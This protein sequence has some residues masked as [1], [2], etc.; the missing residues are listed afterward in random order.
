MANVFATKDDTTV[1][2][3]NN[4]GDREEKA[5]VKAD[6][7]YLWVTAGMDPTDRVH[8]ELTLS[9]G[10][11]TEDRDIRNDDAFGDTSTLK[12]ELRVWFNGVR[13]DWTWLAS[14]RQLFRLG[15]EGRHLDATYDYDLDG[16]DFN[17]FSP[18][19]LLTFD[20]HIHESVEGDEYSAW[21][22]WR[23]QPVEPLTVELGLRWDKQTYTDLD[24]DDQVSPRIN[25]AWQ[26]EDD[27]RLR[28]AWGYFHQAQRINEMN[29]EDGED[30]FHPAQ[31][32]E[33]R[34]IGI[35]HVFD[36]GLSMRL[37]LYQKKYT[38]VIPRYE[39]LFDPLEVPGEA[40][41]DRVRIA[42]DRTEAHGVEFSLK[43][44]W[45]ERIDWWGSYT[46]S[47][48]EDHIDGQDIPR[49]WDQRHATTVG[50]N[51]SGRKWDFSFVHTFHSGWPRTDASAEIIADDD[52]NDI[53]VIVPGPRNNDNLDNYHRLDMRASRRVT[54]PRG[55][56]RYYFEVYNMYDRKN[57]C[58][59]QGFE[60]VGDGMG[61]AELKQETAAWLPLIPSFGVSYTF[62]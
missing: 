14:P 7:Q 18:D 13:T 30:F 28:A 15:A 22:A 52:G 34:V 1:I 23:F 4:N 58:C 19:R 8:G 54:L 32:A 53:A 41:S 60:I 55:I 9:T 24:D 12:D 17:I 3:N 43:G 20:R 36:N 33:H 5:K 45:G 62:K 50:V 44:Q 38:D 59:T 16:N 46:F 57:Q 42:P 35:D 29:V 37:D 25:L 11:V 27:T 21:G 51:W 10:L 39:N 6:S 47:E 26:F 48:V 40:Q 56:L 61:G 31:R 49:S 2:N